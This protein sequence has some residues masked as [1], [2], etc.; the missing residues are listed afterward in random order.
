MARL[1]GVSWYRREGRLMVS[2]TV[3]GASQEEAEAA[4]V[5]RLGAVQVRATAV[6]S[7]PLCR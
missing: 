7:K 2:A 5:E 6:R 1:E 4:A 3:E